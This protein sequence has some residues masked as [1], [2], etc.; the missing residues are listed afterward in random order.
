MEKIENFPSNNILYWEFGIEI[1]SMIKAHIFFF[2]IF[3]KLIQELQNQI[4]EHRIDLKRAAQV[5][6]EMF[7]ALN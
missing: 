1:P 2:P 6:S 4:T 3:K 7:I 5:G